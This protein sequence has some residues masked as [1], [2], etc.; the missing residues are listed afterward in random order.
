MFMKKLFLLLVVSLTMFSCLDN[1]EVG[2]YQYIQVN[3]LGVAF[4]TK[5]GIGYYMIGEELYI[6]D[7]PKGEKRQISVKKRIK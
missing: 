7:Y 1:N 5:T 4:D 6:L 2:R 3:E